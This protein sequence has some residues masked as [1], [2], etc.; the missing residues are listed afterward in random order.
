MNFFEIF[1]QKIYENRYFSCT[2]YFTII[3]FFKY[4]GWNEN[5]WSVQDFNH[6]E[7]I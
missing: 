3:V 4:Y 1:I 6:S 5:D 2:N 7:K